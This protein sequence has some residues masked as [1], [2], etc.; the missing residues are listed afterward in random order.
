MIVNAC[1][2]WHIE[3]VASEY[4]RRYNKA[5]ILIFHVV[6]VVL[7]NFVDVDRRYP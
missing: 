6:I 4:L 7:F 5:N 2:Y 1:E 3:K